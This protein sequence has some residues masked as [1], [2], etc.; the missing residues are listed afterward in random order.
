MRTKLFLGL[1]FVLA[2]LVFAAPAAGAAGKPSTPPPIAAPRHVFTL[3]HETWCVGDVGAAVACDVTIGES[4]IHR[5]GT[6]ATLEVAP[7]P[8][9]RLRDVAPGS[10][11]AVR[12]TPLDKALRLEELLRALP[13][14]ARR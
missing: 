2:V 13:A 6:H 1:S 10:P 3:F 8:L 12:L 14:P 7:G 9:D 4:A 5:M 11:D